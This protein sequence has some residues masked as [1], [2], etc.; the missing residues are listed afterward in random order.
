[1]P[2]LLARRGW[3]GASNGKTDTPRETNEHYFVLSHNQTQHGNELTTN[4]VSCIGYSFSSKYRSPTRSVRSMVR[5]AMVTIMLGS[6]P[7]QRQE[8]FSHGTDGTVGRAQ[9][10]FPQ[11]DQDGGWHKMLACQDRTGY[12]LKCIFWCT[13]ALG[14]LVQGCA[15]DFVSEIRRTNTYMT[16]EELVS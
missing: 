12:P 11:Q 3:M 14:A 2:L 13:I 1:M 16:H 7:R 10:S 9:A 8:R 6:L 5:Q 4:H 15:S